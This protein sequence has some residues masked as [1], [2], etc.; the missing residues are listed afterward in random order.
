MKKKG[1]LKTAE[2]RAAQ[3]QA[4]VRRTLREQFRKRRHNFLK[5]AHLLS[6]DCEA[7]IYVLI[8]R[9]GKYFTFKTSDRPSWPPSQEEIVIMPLFKSPFLD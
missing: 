9:G 7:E 6:E 8:S 5:S 3:E 4:T 1:S 2:R